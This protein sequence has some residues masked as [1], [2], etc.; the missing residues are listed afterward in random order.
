MW[1]R[2]SGMSEPTGDEFWG[3]GAFGGFTRRH[4]F[5]IGVPVQYPG[6]SDPCL[7]QWTCPGATVD[8][9]YVQ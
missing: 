2:D 1:E 3:E 4:R 6:V 8:I 7:N 9:T 5:G